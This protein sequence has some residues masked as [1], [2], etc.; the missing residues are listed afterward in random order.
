MA[1]WFERFTGENVAVKATETYNECYNAYC[2]DC[3]YIKEKKSN[4][5]DQ[6]NH[7]IEQINSYKAEI[8]EQL[9]PRLSK[10]METIHDVSVREILGLESISCSELRF[11]PAKDMKD[12][13]LVDFDNNKFLENLKA[14]FT[15]GFLTRK[16]A[17]ESSI[18][19]DEEVKRMALET[20]RMY[21]EL[22][23]V[24]TI[25]SAVGT[26]EF[27]LSDLVH[28][29]RLMLVRFD[30]TIKYM[31][32]RSLMYNHM[33]LPSNMNLR[34]LPEVM[35]KEVQAMMTAAEILKDICERKIVIE[36]IDDQT[37]L[38]KLI[39]VKEEIT[40]ECA[41]KISSLKSA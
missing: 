31:Q 1:S 5:D 14:I 21:A 22:K 41:E 38:D 16:R 32:M 19:V 12:L 17:N 26:I 3:E 29:F 37:K 24:E 10:L 7:H 9:F 23:K 25:E 2:K 39:E 36:N 4:L 30:G 28:L 15:F 13:I 20:E 40:N 11:E 27:Y 18:R 35:I 33:V 8:K 6:I 34:N